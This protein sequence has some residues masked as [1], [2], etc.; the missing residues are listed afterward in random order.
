MQIKTPDAMSDLE[1]WLCYLEQLHP[2]TIDLGLDRV[3]QVADRLDL[4]QPAPSQW[5]GLM[6]KE[7]LVARLR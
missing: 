1:T 7:R 2:S 4:L 3:K 6:V 5:R